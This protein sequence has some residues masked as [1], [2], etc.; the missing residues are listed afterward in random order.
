MNYLIMLGS[1]MFYGSNGV[2]SYVNDGRLV[3]FF[4]VREIYKERST[5]SYLAIDCDI[6]DAENKRIIKLAKNNPVTSSGGLKIH[7][8]KQL[9]SVKGLSGELIIK[10][11]QLD[12]VSN[13][14][15]DFE[16]F[17]KVFLNRPHAGRIKSHLEQIY[18]S[19][20]LRITGHFNVG[21]HELL[22]E[23]DYLTVDN[24]GKLMG[25]FKSAEH[26]IILQQGGFSF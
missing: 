20:A 5:G 11:E 3:N 15:I 9:T 8:D 1:N 6:R 10:I 18:I 4:K 14:L 16:P 17:K 2:I 24:A 19:A 21:P 22:I 13:S 7:C 12:L 25:N 26:G 23:D